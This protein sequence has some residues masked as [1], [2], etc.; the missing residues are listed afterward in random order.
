V[1][2]DASAATQAVARYLGVTID[3]SAAVQ[4]PKIEKQTEGESRAWA[5][6]YA[7]SQGSAAEQN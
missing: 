2:A 6:R 3:A 1:V 5:E 7:R 4:V